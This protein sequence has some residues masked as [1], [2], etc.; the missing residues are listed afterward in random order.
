[1]YVNSV[2]K[3]LYT[4][5]CAVRWSEWTW[6]SPFSPFVR[7]LWIVKTPL[8][9]LATDAKKQKK[10]NP[11]RFIFDGRKFWG[12]C[13]NV[14]DIMWGHIYFSTCEKFGRKFCPKCAMTFTP[15]ITMTGKVVTTKCWTCYKTETWMP[16]LTYLL[17]H[18]IVWQLLLNHVKVNRSSILKSVHC[19]D[20]N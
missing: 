6:Q 16:T 9:M 10:S 7:W 12:Q 5:L 8:K 3:D 20:A 18:I 11:I 19:Y 2:C 15:K 13:V 1:M 17:R 14:I 4:V